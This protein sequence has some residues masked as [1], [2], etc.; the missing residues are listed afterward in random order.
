MICPSSAE[1]MAREHSRTIVNRRCSVVACEPEVPNLL[2]SKSPLI[3][4]PDDLVI[5][6][7]I[8]LLEKSGKSFYG[9]PL[10]LGRKGEDNTVLYGVT[11]DLLRLRKN[12]GIEHAVAVIGREAKTVSTEDT[13]DRLVRFLRRLHTAVVY[14]PQTAAASLCR[15]LLSVAQWVVTR[16]R[17]LFQLVSENVQVIVPDGSCGVEEVVSVESLK[18]SL[19]IRPAQIP[20]F[21]ALTQGVK[22]LFS[23]RQAIRL[24]EIRDNLGQLLRDTSAVPSQH[25][26]R[27]LSANETVLLKRLCDMRLEATRP[28]ARFQRSQLAF[29]KDEESA[30]GILSEY[31]FWS[32]IGLL[33]RSMTTGLSVSTTAKHGT[34]Y[35]AIRNEAGMRELEAA[36]SNSEVCAIDTE[37]TDK[38]PRSASLLGVAFAMRAGKAFYVPLTEVDLEGTSTEVIKTCLHGLLAGR[39][40][41]VGHNIKFDCVLL[42]Q[43]GIAIKHVSFD[44]MLAAY[45]CFG[46]WESFNLAALSKKLL[47]KDIKRYKDVVGKGETL[48][49]VPFNEVVEHACADADVTLQLYHRLTKELEKRKLLEQFSGGPMVLLRTL[50]DKEHN[51]VR[52]NLRAIHRRR[53]VLTTEADVLRTAVIAEAGQEFDLNSPT[54]T[55]AVLRRTNPFI[56]QPGLR[57]SLLRMEQL[58][59]THSLPRLI[60]KY[61]RVRKLI[62]ELDAICSSIKSNKVFSIFSQVRWAHG[63]C[64]RRVRGSAT[65]MDP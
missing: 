9:A 52:L 57:L 42:R 45:E 30:T 27:K 8:F 39:T 29:I 40:S 53:K 14:E 49:D 48:L 23:R 38:D 22:A 44:T 5:I 17:V 50:A 43:H 13:I 54:E 12:L 62:R 2:L 20:S 60:V 61:T 6:D 63:S 7:V 58:G 11:R 41:F 4:P 18:T 15:N 46:D 16:N 19:G 37:A 28:P 35:Q 64:R 65:Q 10:I 1:L 47:G 56:E 51:G 55:A 34:A 3:V 24:L 59:E 32:L 25:L 33:P 21:L 26:R 31:D 36:L